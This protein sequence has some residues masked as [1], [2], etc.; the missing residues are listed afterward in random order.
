MTALC[1][2]PYAYQGFMAAF[3][4]KYLDCLK[5]DHLWDNYSI[6]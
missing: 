3:S 4:P 6:T 2:Y 5:L 1:C